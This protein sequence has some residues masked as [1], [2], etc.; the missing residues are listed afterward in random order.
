MVH[1][2]PISEAEFWQTAA[3]Q[4]LISHEHPRRFARLEWE[5]ATHSY[6]LSWRSDLI[7]P[8][9]VS[10]SDQHTIWIGVDQQVAAVDVREG[11]IRL[12]LPLNH[13]LLQ[14]LTLPDS[15]AVLTETEIWL[16]NEDCSVRF[17]ERLP[18]IPGA[19]SIDEASGLLFFSVLSG[20]KFVIDPE[21]GRL[22]SRQ[23]FELRVS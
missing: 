1:F 19:I 13:Q 20:E 10:S 9:I 7:E 12:L 14:I 16:F 22:E 2:Q 23:Q 3:C 11:N 5:N 17:K 15:T 8:E 6:A 21:T 4:R 18:D